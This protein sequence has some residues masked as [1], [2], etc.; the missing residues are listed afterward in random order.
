MENQSS[1]LIYCESFP[2]LPIS[3]VHNYVSAWI[4]N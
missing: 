2:H 4:W 1:L 3:C